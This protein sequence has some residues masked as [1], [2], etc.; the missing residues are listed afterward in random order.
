MSYKFKKTKRRIAVGKNPGEKYVATIA[1]EGKV[2]KK[3]IMEFIE[4]DSSIAAPDIEI[5]IGALS[6]AVSE[7]SELS[8]AINLKEL[9]VFSPNLRTT[10]EDVKA[11]VSATNIDDVVVNF[12]PASEFRRDMDQA[13][14]SET[15]RYKIKHE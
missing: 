7:N 4:H 10:G 13:P 14:V 11:N 8:R 5:L 1:I 12:R 9:G 15:T 2:N 6:T 3:Q